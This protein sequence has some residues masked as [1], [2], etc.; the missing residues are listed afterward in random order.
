[1]P[2]AAPE[3]F[4]AAAEALGKVVVGVKLVPSPDDSSRLVPSTPPELDGRKGIQ[5]GIV[6]DPPAAGGVCRTQEAHSGPGQLPLLETVAATQVLGAGWSAPAGP[7]L[8]DFCGGPGSLPNVSAQRLLA[9]DLIPE[10]VTGR[11]VLVGTRAP[12]IGSGFHTPTTASRRMALLEYQGHALN[13]LLADRVIREPDSLTRLAIILSLLFV[14]A[15]VSRR[16]TLQL[17]FWLTLVVIGFHALVSATA[18]VGF[19]T[20]LPVSENVVGLVALMVFTVRGRAIEV[21]AS[22]KNLISESAGILKDKCWPVHGQDVDTTWSLVA[23]MIDQT[24]DLKRLIFLQVDPGS[25]RL[26]TILA[27]HCSIDDMAE[28]RRDSTRPPYKDAINAKG[29]IVVENFLGTPQKGERQ[30]LIPLVFCGELL[31]FWAMGIDSAKLAAIPEFESLLHDYTSRMG[32]LLHQAMDVSQSG[33]IDARA[34]LRFGA[35]GSSEPQSNLKSTLNLLQHRLGALDVLINSLDAGVIVFDI[36]GRIL[37]INDI[38]LSLL[39][40][41][42]LVP[43]DMSALDVI[44]TLSDFDLSRARKLLRRVIVESLPVSFPVKLR[45]SPGSRYLF[46]L[47]PLREISRKDERGRS[48]QGGGKEHSLRAGGHHINGNSPRNEAPTDRKA[49]HA[50][51]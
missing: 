47:K 16:A 8:I 39:K 18:L 7:Y 31:G 38:M 51:P 34:K 42:S 1:M 45:S 40:K 11:C 30:Y 44:T 24:L 26:K 37:Q 20:W 46:H 32:E 25:S 50:T 35:G 36:F 28:R 49:L 41:E 13:T 14:C 33:G 9:G 2:D 22:L 43:F 6:A 48:R 12:A 27:L 3:S 29:P 21:T 15:S 10:L 17:S 19:R 4:W 23:G 5:K